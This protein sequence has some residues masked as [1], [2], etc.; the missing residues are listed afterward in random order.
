MKY[1][2]RTTLVLDAFT[3][4]SMRGLDNLVL[5]RV[6]LCPGLLALSPGLRFSHPRSFSDEKCHFKVSCLFREVTFSVRALF[7]NRRMPERAGKFESARGEFAKFKAPRTFIY[8]LCFKLG[9]KKI[10]KYTSYC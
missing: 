5:L 9:N 2:F 6:G 1:V 4:V 10:H 3:F 7:T 8:R